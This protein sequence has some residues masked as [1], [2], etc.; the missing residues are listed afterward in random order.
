MK[1]TPRR[2]M[3]VKVYPTQDVREWGKW[4]EVARVWY[5]RDARV[6]GYDLE[7]GMWVVEDP[8]TF[9]TLYT[10]REELEEVE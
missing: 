6:L 3:A 1:I 10:N 7:A 8:I 9:E 2:G 5:G 4:I